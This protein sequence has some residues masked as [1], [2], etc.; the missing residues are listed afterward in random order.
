MFS[1]CWSFGAPSLSLGLTASGAAE[2]G[3]V[4][5]PTCSCF[6][7]AAT[8]TTNTVLPLALLLLLSIVIGPISESEICENYVT[9]SKK[10]VKPE[11]RGTLEFSIY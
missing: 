10:Y 2:F 9:I 8:V 5:A 6:T 3:S 1:L 4:T 7:S 11:M